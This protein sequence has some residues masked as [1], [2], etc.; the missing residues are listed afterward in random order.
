M[1]TKMNDAQTHQARWA[2]FR[3]SVIGPLLSCP[4]DEGELKECLKVLSKKS[5]KHRKPHR[6]PPI[7]F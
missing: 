6:I 4:P 7:L 1:T 3:F 5:W 2:H